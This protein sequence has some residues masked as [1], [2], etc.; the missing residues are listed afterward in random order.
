MIDWLISGFI[1]S[2]FCQ[3]HAID[4]RAVFIY[5]ALNIMHSYFFSHLDWRY[6]Y[7]SAALADLLIMIV[8]FGVGTIITRKVFILLMAC[9]CSIL[10]NFAGYILAHIPAAVTA[11]SFL[12]YILYGVAL[13]LTFYNFKADDDVHYFKR[14]SYSGLHRFLADFRAR[15]PYSDSSLETTP[16]GQRQ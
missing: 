11:Y 10:I 2:A 13:L 5:G 4:R 15:L 16:G 1:I 6:Y 8:V 12:M 14:G 9:L 7:A 3:R